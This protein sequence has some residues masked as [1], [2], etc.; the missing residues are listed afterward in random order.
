MLVNSLVIIPVHVHVHIPAAD[1]TMYTSP[2][3]IPTVKNW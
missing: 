3:L 1:D 2:T